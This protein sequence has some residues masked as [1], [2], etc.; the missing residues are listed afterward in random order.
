LRELVV[1]NNEPNT[2]FTVE[3]LW[4]LVYSDGTWIRQAQIAS[5]HSSQSDFITRGFILAG[6]DRRN[7]GPASL[8]HGL[9]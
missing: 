7:H 5:R 1:L 6:L 9:Y 4:A 8:K 3:E 2:S